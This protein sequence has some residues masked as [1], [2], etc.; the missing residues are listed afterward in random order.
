M[1][2]GPGWDI[3]LQL[4]LR[5]TD[6]SFPPGCVPFLTG[7]EHA[8]GWPLASGPRAAAGAG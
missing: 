6:R 5:I 3:G 7:K 2:T 8:P 4:G 1:M